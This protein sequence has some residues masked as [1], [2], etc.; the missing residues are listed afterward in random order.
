MEIPPKKIWKILELI[1]L[2]IKQMYQDF[3][4]HWLP[5]FMME[6]TEIIDIDDSNFSSTNIEQFPKK[7]TTYSNK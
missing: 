2:V 5:F 6:G 4:C 3:D 1:A 7:L